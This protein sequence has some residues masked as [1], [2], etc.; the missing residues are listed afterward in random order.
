[1]AVAVAV[2][3]AIVPMLAEQPVLSVELAVEHRVLLDRAMAQQQAA[4]PVRLVLEG[5]QVVLLP[6]AVRVARHYLVVLVLH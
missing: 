2:A 3:T 4:A 5:L 6:V 1:M